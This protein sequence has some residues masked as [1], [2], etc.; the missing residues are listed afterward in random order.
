M[1]QTPTPLEVAWRTLVALRNSAEVTVAERAPCALTLYQQLLDLADQ[2]QLGDEAADFAARTLLRLMTQTMLAPTLAR[3]VHRQIVKYLARCLDTEIRDARRRG[4]P[5]QPE[6]SPQEPPPQQPS[7]TPELREFLRRFV[8]A[9][10]QPLRKRTNAPAHYERPVALVE[11][12]QRH[13]GAAPHAEFVAGLLELNPV[14]EARPDDR[15]RA[16]RH[17]R[18][19]RW[20]HQGIRQRRATRALSEDDSEDFHRFVDALRDRQARARDRDDDGEAER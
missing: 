18:C 20:L 6:R 15:T 13:A 1:S 5:S 12:L 16:D 10:V 14:P 8:E 2:K 4:R 17:C 7:A 9:V 3:M 19:R 11:L